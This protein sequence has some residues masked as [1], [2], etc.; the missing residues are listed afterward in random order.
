MKVR[1]EAAWDTAKEE[2]VGDREA[3]QRLV[4]PH[5]KFWNA[6]LKVPRV[7]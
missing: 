1:R 2:I 7:S 3:N 6:E 5:R 4:H